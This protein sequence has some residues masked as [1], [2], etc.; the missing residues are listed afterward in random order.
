[1]PT[2]V[3]ITDPKLVAFVEALEA[4][5]PEAAAVAAVPVATEILAVL[6]PKLKPELAVAATILPYV[7]RDLPTHV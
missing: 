1:M 4:K 6:W 5:N 3:T 7:A 2:Q